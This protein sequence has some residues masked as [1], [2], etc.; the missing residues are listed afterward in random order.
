MTC[1]ASCSASRLF[2]DTRSCSPWIA[3]WTPLMLAALTVFTISRAFSSAMP[4]L[5]STSILKPPPPVGLTPLV[6]SA[7]REM[8]RFTIFSL[9]TSRA[10]STR[11]SAFALR[12]IL[13]LSVHSIFASVPLKSHRCL[14][15]LRAWFS[16]LSTSCRSTSETTSNDA[17]LAISRVYS[18]RPCVGQPARAGGY[19]SGQTGLTVNQVAQPSEVRTLFLPLFLER[20][21]GSREQDLQSFESSKRSE[22][23]TSELQSPYDIVCRLLLE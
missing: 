1:I 3:T 10:A 23:H 13:S 6:F 17:S 22:E 19:R 21:E 9:K 7:L 11:C 4:W 2:P 18:M 14:S 5:I 16:A 8:W 15:S 12:S 20:C